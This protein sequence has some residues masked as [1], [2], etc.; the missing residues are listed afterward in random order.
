[1]PKKKRTPTKP[2]SAARQAPRPATWQETPA[3]KALS[4]Q[5]YNTV[6]VESLVRSARREV[7]RLETDGASL[8]LDDATRERLA[9]TGRILQHAMEMLGSI[10]G[11]LDTVQVRENAG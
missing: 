10:G 3:E 9:D 8:G 7:W 1:M 11:A 5:Q 4:E 2:H 6:T